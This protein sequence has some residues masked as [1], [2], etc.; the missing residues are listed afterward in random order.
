MDTFT[1]NVKTAFEA[2]RER[3][4]KTWNIV[5]VIGQIFT[6]MG[7]VSFIMLVTAACLKILLG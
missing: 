4:E 3:T 1:T 6:G 2:K 5:G 7:A